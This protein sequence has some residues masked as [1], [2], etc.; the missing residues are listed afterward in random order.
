MQC[1]GVLQV[2][3]IPVVTQRLIPMVRVSMEISQFRV[4]KVV[5]ALFHAGRAGSSQSFTCP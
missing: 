1:R 4:Y 5:D 3:G 2:V